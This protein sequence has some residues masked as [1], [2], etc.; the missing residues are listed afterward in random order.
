MAGTALSPAIPGPLIE[1]ASTFLPRVHAGSVPSTGCRCRA[2]VNWTQ[3]QPVMEHFAMGCHEPP[4][5]KGRPRGDANGHFSTKSKKKRPGHRA[6]AVSLD[7]PGSSSRTSGWIR[8]TQNT[9]PS[10]LPTPALLAVAAAKRIGWRRRQP[11]LAASIAVPGSRHPS[12]ENRPSVVF[13]P[14]ASFPGYITPNASRPKPG[15]RFHQW[16]RPWWSFA[17]L[18]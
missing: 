1:S 7:L 10:F 18:P 15:L 3:I 2:P 8:R 12:L 6:P 16:D 17:V 5:T 13:S 9:F 14:V 4:G 11:S